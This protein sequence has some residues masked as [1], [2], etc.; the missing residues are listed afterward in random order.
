MQCWVVVSGGGALVSGFLQRPC[1]GRCAVLC[2][3]LRRAC[4]W[5]LTTPAMH[6]ATPQNAGR[7]WGGGAGHG[8]PHNSKQPPKR[9]TP[10]NWTRAVGGGLAR[11]QGGHAAGC[12]D[13]CGF[14]CFARSGSQKT[15][16]S[17]ATRQT[18]PHNRAAAAWAPL[19][20]CRNERAGGSSTDQVQRGATG[21][22]MCW[23]NGVMS[24]VGMGAPQGPPLGR[25]GARLRALPSPRPSVVSCFGA[26][27]LATTAGGG[28]GRRRGRAAAPS[29]PTAPGAAWPALPRP[30]LGPSCWAPPPRL[31]GG[32]GLGA[33]R[34]LRCCEARD[35]HAQGAAGAGFGGAGASGHCQGPGSGEGAA[36]GRLAGRSAAVKT[37]AWLRQRSHLETPRGQTPGQTPVKRGQPRTCRTRSRARRR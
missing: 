34:G 20:P 17:V 15:P 18:Q 37:L 28:L 33:E 32:G 24:G 11:T 25:G 35:G 26:W 5:L 10:R 19:P 13:A 16:A 2:C 6:T 8:T 9:H 29:R 22:G 36:E 27:P 12:C 30:G 14:A 23:G 3:W 21:R 31:L 4:G 1:S 7:A